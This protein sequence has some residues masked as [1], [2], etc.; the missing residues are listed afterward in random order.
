MEKLK[1]FVE[2][3]KKMVLGTL[4]VGGLFSGYYYLKRVNN[5]VANTKDETSFHHDP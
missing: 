4:I 2:E 1:D 3:N 5:S